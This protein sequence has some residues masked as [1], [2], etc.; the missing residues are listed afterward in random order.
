[1]DCVMCGS[2]AV[3]QCMPCKAVLCEEHKTQHEQIKKKTHNFERVGLE[4]TPDQSSQIFANLSSKINHANECTRRIIKETRTHISEIR[5]ISMQSLA[6][7]S[8]KSQYY[9][10]LA[11]IARKSLSRSE[12]QTLEEELKTVPIVHDPS[13]KFLNVQISS[14]IE[15]INNYENPQHLVTNQSRIPNSPPEIFPSTDYRSNPLSN[16]MMPDISVLEGHTSQ[17]LSVAVTHDNKYIISGSADRTLKVWNLLEKKHEFSLEGHTSAVHCVLVTLDNEYIVSGSADKTLIMWNFQK[18]KKSGVLKHHTSPVLC[19]AITRDNK[20]LVSGSADKSVMM[21]DIR[22]KT[23][24]GLLTGHSAPVLSLVVTMDSYFIVSA[25]EDKTVRL[26]AVQHKQFRVLFQGHTAAV[27]C[28]AVT[29]DNLHIVSGSLDKTIRMWSI[30]Q[31]CQLL[32][33]QG[34]NSSV[35][36]IAIT[37]DCRFIVYGL[38][39]QVEQDNTL[40]IWNLMEGR[41]DNLLYGHGDAISSVAITDDN[42][43]IISGSKDN[44]IRIWSP[45]GFKKRSSSALILAPDARERPQSEKSLCSQSSGIKS[46]FSKFTDDISNL[47]IFK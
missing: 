44:T 34:N 11:E 30:A 17:I 32:M 45:P 42:Q 33:I 39:N 35:N 41:Q 36:C 2:D 38:G 16:P 9:Y 15:F 27:T 31:K 3:Y 24:I 40:R 21:W 23:K 46:M 25:S 19:L 1:M 18:K 28:L 10:R 22:N 8:N 7:I 47:T 29:S 26:W 5:R 14:N 20:C 12:K 6:V 43:Y 4:L 13:Y 37:S